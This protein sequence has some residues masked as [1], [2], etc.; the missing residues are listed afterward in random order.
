MNDFS[1]VGII[2][3]INEVEVCRLVKVSSV[4]DIRDI[5]DSKSKS[6]LISKKLFPEAKE[7][8]GKLKSCCLSFLTSNAPLLI[9][10]DSKMIKL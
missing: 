1:I 6:V 9:N 8:D 5:L 10:C 7:H 2:R 4:E 3:N